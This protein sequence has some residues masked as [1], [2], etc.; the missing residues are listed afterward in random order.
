[1]TAALRPATGQSNTTSCSSAGSGRVVAVG[2]SAVTVTVMRSVCVILG[3]QSMAAGF[4]PDDCYA[5]RHEISA[6]AD[7]RG[8]MSSSRCAVV[9]PEWRRAQ[10]RTEDEFGNS[11]MTL[12]KR[13]L[14]VVED[15]RAMAHV[16]RFNFEKAGFEVQVASNGLE[17]VRCVQDGQFDVIVTDQQMPVMDGTAFCA[18]MRKLDAYRQVPAIMLTAKGLELEASQLKEELGIAAVFPKPFS[19]SQLVQ[20]VEELLAPAV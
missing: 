1:M 5:G 19:P 15:N 11:Q 9:S 14:L 10:G 6:A 3:D 2:Q 13:R 12:A 7:Y 17:G 20:A 18:Q 8:P 4:T 16:I